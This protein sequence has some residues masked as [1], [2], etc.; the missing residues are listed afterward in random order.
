MS[1]QKRKAEQGF[2]VIAEKGKGSMGWFF[3]FKLHIIINDRGQI[4]LPHYK[5]QC[6][7]QTAAQGQDLPQQGVQEDIRR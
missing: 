6:G 4:I 5:G 3:G 2:K 1:Y 7:R